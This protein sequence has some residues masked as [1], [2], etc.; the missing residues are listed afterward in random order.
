MEKS[1]DEMRF[2]VFLASVALHSVMATCDRLRTAC[3]IVKDKRLRGVGYNGSI[4]GFPHCDESEHIIEDGHCIATRHGEVNAIT[5]T[6]RQHLRDGQAIVIATPCIDCMK[7][8]A[9]EGITRIDYIGAYNNSK[10]KD[11][12]SEIAK[13]R[14]IELRQHDID[15]AEVFQYLFD[16]LARKGGILYRAGYRLRIAKEELK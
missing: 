6:D 13:L 14:K 15:W 10:G 8:L 2:L 11:Y 4:S 9:E 1:R 16:L 3:G 7:D 5:N 12:I